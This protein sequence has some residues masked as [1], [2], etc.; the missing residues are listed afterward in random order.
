MSRREPPERPAAAPPEQVE[1][2]PLGKSIAA[3][4]QFPSA[5]AARSFWDDPDYRRVVHLR[6]ERGTF[7]I[8]IVPGVDE[9]TWAPLA[10][11]ST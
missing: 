2:E 9:S 11:P 7:Q 4:F 3:I 5:A 6:Q 8:S 10:P 1:G